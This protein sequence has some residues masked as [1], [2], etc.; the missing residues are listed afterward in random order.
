MQSNLKFICKNQTLILS[1]KRAIFWR[2]QRALLV[3]DLHIGKAGHFRKAGIP[4]PASLTSNDLRRLGQL[5]DEFMPKSCLF[6]GDLFHSDYNNEFL[7]LKAFI[8]KYSMVQFTLIKGNHDIVNDQKIEDLGISSIHEILE[9]TPF[10]FTHHPQIDKRLYN[11]AGHLHPGY[12]IRG[13]AKQSLS[14]PVF[15]FG[16]KHAVLPAFSAFSGKALVQPN[17]G[18][19]IFG[20]IENEILEINLPES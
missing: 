20:V 12:R 10:Q 16:E 3:A 9:I 14:T 5:I 2:A 7:L 4:L 1:G 8:E 6:L 17:L 11:I 19:S 13:I 15:Y 18:D